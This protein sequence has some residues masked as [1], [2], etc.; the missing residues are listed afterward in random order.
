V[1]SDEPTRQKD[2]LVSEVMTRDVLT[3]RPTDPV[4]A[5]VNLIVDHRIT[6]VPVV[7]DE[8]RCVGIVSESDVLSRR[9]RTVGEIMTTEVIAVEEDTSLAEAAE[10]L[11]TRRI[12]RLPVT[13][14][15]RLV[16]ILTRMDLLRRYAQTRWTCRWCG[17]TERGLRPPNACPECGGEDW[18][19]TVE[20]R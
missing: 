14:N 5:A 1:I 18:Q 13:R 8:G 3:V 16:G 7:D 9:G 6:G 20:T 19:F 2:S 17:H 10:T 4:E 12:R 11:L 15:G